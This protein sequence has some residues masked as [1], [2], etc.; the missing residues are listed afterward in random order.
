ME[1]EELCDLSLS[2][3]P[4]RWGGCNRCSEGHRACVCTRVWARGCWRGTGEQS[5]QG[6]LGLNSSSQETFERPGVTDTPLLHP[7]QHSHCV[8]PR[9]HSNKW[10]HGVDPA[11]LFSALCVLLRSTPPLIRAHLPPQERQIPFPALGQKEVVCW[12]WGDGG[13]GGK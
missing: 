13:S 7:L 8:P 5:S 3:I 6:K 9:Q 4:P 10:F 1:E 11:T 12:G 2:C